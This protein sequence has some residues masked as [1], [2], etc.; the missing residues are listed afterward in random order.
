MSM[1]PREAKWH[2]AAQRFCGQASLAQTCWASPSAR[3]S[4]S[5]QDGQSAGKAHGTESSGRNSRTGPTTSGM[6][7]PA[8]RTTTVSP[9]R[10]SLIRTWSSLWSVAMATVEPPTKTGAMTAKGVALPVLPIETWMSRSVVVR[11]S[12]GSL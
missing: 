6:T 7:S 12:G 1:A 11:S 8:L 2:T 9:G 10:T 5:P 4:G 3:T